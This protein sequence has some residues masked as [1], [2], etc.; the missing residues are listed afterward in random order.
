MDAT[1]MT[2][3]NEG[4]AGVRRRER[5]QLG[6]FD[7]RT[8]TGPGLEEHP[9]QG[10]QGPC[11]SQDERGARQAGAVRSGSGEGEGPHPLTDPGRAC[12]RRPA[13]PSGQ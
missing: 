5:D 1:T 11:G 10:H 2:T 12:A 13:R 7:A 9:D 4:D 8:G 6:T 3:T